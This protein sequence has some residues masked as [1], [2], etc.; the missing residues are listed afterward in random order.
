MD[1]NMAPPAH[2]SRLP[3]RTWLSNYELSFL[4]PKRPPATSVEVSSG[5]SSTEGSAYDGI[6]STT[7]AWLQVL[8]NHLVMMNSFGLIQS[9]GIFQLPYEH[10]LKSSP[11]TV[12]WVGSIH[13]FFVYFLGT[14]SDWALDRGYY[15]RILFLG[16][17]FQIIGLIVAGFSKTFWMTFLFHGV[18]QGI[19][20]GLMFC[21]TVTTTAVYSKDSKSKTTALGITGCGASTGGI[22]FPLIAK[23]TFHSRGID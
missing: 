22:V 8:V 5:S 18:F 10:L 7:Q 17:V 9:F 2:N 14:F 13:I 19:G 4:K 16:S 3:R 6:A 21:P 11:S 23:Y 20:H 15:K 1:D 12:A